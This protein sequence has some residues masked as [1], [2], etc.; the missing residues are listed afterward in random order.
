M[1]MEAQEQNFRQQLRKS[2]D[3][4]NQE[5][6][7]AQKAK[8]ETHPPSHNTHLPSLFYSLRYLEKEVYTNT[9]TA[10]YHLQFNTS[11]R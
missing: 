4:Y 2:L 10:L 5:L 3:G 11:S 1:E 9:P 7:E 8:G 6:A